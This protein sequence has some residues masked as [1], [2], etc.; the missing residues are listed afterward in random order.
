M[1]CAGV[2][3]RREDKDK[4]CNKGYHI[5]NRSNIQAVGESVMHTEL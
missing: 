3:L 4:V 2:G 5:G 1:L